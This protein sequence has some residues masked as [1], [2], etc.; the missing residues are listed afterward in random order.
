MVLDGQRLL[1]LLERGSELAAVLLRPGR[2]DVALEHVVLV[3]AVQLHLLPVRPGARQ[4]DKREVGLARYGPGGGVQVVV[5]RWNPLQARL[6]WPF[7][8]RGRVD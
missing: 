1:G 3:L 8:A 2:Q 5:Q 6:W 4:P 7:E